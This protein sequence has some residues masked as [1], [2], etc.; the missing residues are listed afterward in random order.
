MGLNRICEITAKPLPELKTGCSSVMV[1]AC[2][3]V[4]GPELSP[5]DFQL[6]HRLLNILSMDDSHL[7][8]SGHHWDAVM[9]S[10]QLLEIINIK[11]PILKSITILKKSKELLNQAW[12]MRCWPTS[13]GVKVKN[14]YTLNHQL[15]KR[16]I[17][18]KRQTPQATKNSYLN[19]KDD[20]YDTNVSISCELM[21]V[22]PFHSGAT[23]PC[24]HWS[25]RSI[26]TISDFIS[27]TTDL[28]SSGGKMTQLSF[29]ISHITSLS[30]AVLV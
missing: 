26:L 25:V 3:S 11:A 6:H 19:Q 23:H 30:Q 15:Q 13:C 8:V 21:V 9:D 24:F 20:K 14:E 5:L 27:T 17:K 18:L 4:L 28:L 29:R 16:C 2:S 1:A 22:L 7:L 10:L 12:S